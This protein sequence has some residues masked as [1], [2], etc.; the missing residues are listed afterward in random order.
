MDDTPLITNIE[1]A[2]WKRGDA[3]PRIQD[4]SGGEWL[5]ITDEAVHVDD[6][7]RG[8]EEGRRKAR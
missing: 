1:N 7:S 8:Q 2:I 4:W 5:Y 3:G 6:V